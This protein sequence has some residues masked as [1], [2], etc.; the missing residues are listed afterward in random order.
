MV[1]GTGKTDHYCAR[2][3]AALRA[4]LVAPSR[5]RVSA[6]IEH[7]GALF[8]ETGAGSYKSRV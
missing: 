4:M 5:H 2:S 1:Q 6:L 3:C 7:P 8:D